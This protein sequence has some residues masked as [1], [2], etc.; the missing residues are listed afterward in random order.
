MHSSAVDETNGSDSSAVEVS[1]CIGAND[2]STADLGLDAVIACF[3][4][5]ASLLLGL[6]CTSKNN[7]KQ[8]RIKIVKRSHTQRG[9]PLLSEL[10]PLLLPLLLPESPLLPP[11][12]CGEGV[13]A[14]V[15]G[16]TPLPLNPVGEG[17]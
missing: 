13:G 6:T 2:I 12:P 8:R 15:G 9:I 7:S 3:S 4:L 16:S 11:T 10:L 17:V 1:G 14:A 5:F